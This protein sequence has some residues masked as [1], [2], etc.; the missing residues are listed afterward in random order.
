[1][2]RRVRRISARL[3]RGGRTGAAV[4]RLTGEIAERARRTVSEARRVARNARRSLGP[5]R[6][7]AV[8][9]DQLERELEAAEEVLA[10][11]ELRLQGQRTIPDRR[12]SLVDPDA[13]PIRRGNP[14]QPTEFGFQ[15]QDR[16]HRRG[17]R[18][19]RRSRAWQ[20]RRRHHARGRDRKGKGGG[21]AGADG[22]SPTAASAPP[23]ATRPWP[24]KACATPS[25]P[26]NASRP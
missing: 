21:R 3:A 25:S 7:R 22:C 1:V 2:G 6:R 13:R 4:D 23:L 9:V 20:P 11:T 19:R 24:A 10:Q 15:G 14:R 8:L 16:R 17:I 18:D 5:G 26:A 12:V